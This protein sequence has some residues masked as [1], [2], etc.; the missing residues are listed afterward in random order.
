MNGTTTKV[1]W[2]LGFKG[3]PVAALCRTSYGPLGLTALAFRDGTVFR[4]TRELTLICRDDKHTDN[5]EHASP[6]RRIS[7]S[8]LAKQHPRPISVHEEIQPK[9]HKD[10]AENSRHGQP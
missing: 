3:G 5:A 2:R 8:P 10:Q 7:Y 1:N 9:R 6:E 4:R